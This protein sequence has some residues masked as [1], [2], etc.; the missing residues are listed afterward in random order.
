M[1]LISAG[2]TLLPSGPEFI[3]WLSSQNIPDPKENT[4]GF[5]E[6]IRNKKASGNIPDCVVY[7][8]ETELGAFIVHP[9]YPNCAS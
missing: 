4:M 2:I 8:P 6:W 3:Q 7:D 1:I 9:N 5:W